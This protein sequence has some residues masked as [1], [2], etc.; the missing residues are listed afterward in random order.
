MTKSPRGQ[1]SS[2][3]ISRGLITEH[4]QQPQHTPVQP[5]EGSAVGKA[6]RSHLHL[7]VK[8][9]LPHYG[10]FANGRDNVQKPGVERVQRFG[11]SQHPQGDG[12]VLLKEKGES[13]SLSPGLRVLPLSIKHSQASL[14]GV[15]ETCLA[16]CAPEKGI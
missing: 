15:R 9:L 12:K 6:G 5:A 7:V 8:H 3:S 2:S 1:L 14:L 11:S 10:T 13:S 4:P 16:G